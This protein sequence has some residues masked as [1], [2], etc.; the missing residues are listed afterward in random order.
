MLKT[1]SAQVDPITSHGLSIP[2]KQQVGRWIGGRR[3]EEEEEGEGKV[4]T[5]TSLTAVVV[6]VVKVVAAGKG[7]RRKGDE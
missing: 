6:V 3:G 2:K 4:S 7:G 1:R 5:S